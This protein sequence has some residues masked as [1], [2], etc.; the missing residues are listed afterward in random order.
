M[1]D[2]HFVIYDFASPISET[3]DN[4]SISSFSLNYDGISI[5]STEP[6]IVP[7]NSPYDILIEMILITKHDIIPHGK[8]ME[9]KTCDICTDSLENTYAFEFPCNNNHVFHRQCV[10]LNILI[11]M[12]THKRPLH[13][14]PCCN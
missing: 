4:A 2:S 8:Y 9:K 14:C 5:G 12:D 1:D 6:F 11:M 7:L 3:K 13:R 10:I